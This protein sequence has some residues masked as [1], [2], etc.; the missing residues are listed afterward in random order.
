MSSIFAFFFNERS[1]HRSLSAP[2]FCAVYT[3]NH[4]PRR[5][6]L[7]LKFSHIKL[8]KHISFILYITDSKALMLRS[9]LLKYS[10]LL[11]LYICSY[12][13]VSPFLLLA[14]LH[15]IESVSVTH[16]TQTSWLGSGPWESCYDWST[17][18]ETKPRKAEG[19]NSGYGH[20]VESW[21]R[22]IL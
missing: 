18:F 9:I 7:M 14:S 22:K 5:E 6:K 20:G 12:N 10:S 16:W 3:D 21:N 8:E 15:I 19:L 11:K 1:S 13:T 2:L 4:G 17:G